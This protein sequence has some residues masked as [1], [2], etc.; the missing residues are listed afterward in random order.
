M[1]ARADL[2]YCARLDRIHKPAK[3]GAGIECVS[4]FDSCWKLFPKHSFY[5]ALLLHNAK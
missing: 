4:E 5:P 3:D 1:V 2:V